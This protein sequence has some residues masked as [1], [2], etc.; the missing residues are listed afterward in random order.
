MY[1][2]RS[3]RID[4]DVSVGPAPPTR[5][6]V[7]SR[8]S[9]PATAHHLEKNRAWL[10]RGASDP[11]WIGRLRLDQVSGPRSASESVQGTAPR[12]KIRPLGSIR[13]N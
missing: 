5:I 3:V 9:H 8:K 11:R 7:A 6:S 13:S 1:A 2:E 4:A 12:T 10:V